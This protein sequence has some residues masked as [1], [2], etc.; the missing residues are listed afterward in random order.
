M[1]QPEA[2]EAAEERILTFLV[3]QRDG[4]PL[5]AIAEAAGMLPSGAHSHLKRLADE[6]RVARTGVGKHVRYRAVP[7]VRT[8][9]TDP[10]RG[11]HLSWRASGET[12]W[13]Y[14][15]VA[16]VP[17]DL[18]RRTLLRMLRLASTRG[19][20]RQPTTW[21]VYGSCARGE[22]RP[23]SDLDLLVLVPK[24]RGKEELMDLVDEANL[25]GLRPVDAQV[26]TLA[27]LRQAA[28]GLRR[29]ILRDGI[30]VHVAS[31]DAPFIET[32]RGE[33]E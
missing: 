33:A 27:Q 16:R 18:A 6:G 22:A 5:Q 28:P 20:G 32:L 19:E 10:E 9:W 4:A 17:D 1:P 29:A 13:S 14:P 24:A 26:L 3:T 21:V 8:T 25:W 7:F 30:T 11:L 2:T 31:E 15:L 23:K 12:S